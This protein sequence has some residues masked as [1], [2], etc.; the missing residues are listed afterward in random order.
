M[1]VFTSSSVT[2]TQVKT[3]SIVVLIVKLGILITTA[4]S[5]IDKKCCILIQL[6]LIIVFKVECTYAIF[7]L[8]Y[9]NELYELFM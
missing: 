4:V 3:S 6:D 1:Y 7:L 9:G 8:K 2:F 5:Y